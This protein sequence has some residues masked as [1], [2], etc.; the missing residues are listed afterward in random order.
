MWRIHFTAEDVARTRLAD[1]PRPLV[2]LNAAVRMLQGATRNVRLGSWRR[3]TLSRLP[4][5]TRMLFDLIPLQEWGLDLLTPAAA[6]SPE[7][8]L[9]QVRTSSRRRL[10]RELS[11]L[12]EQREHRRRLPR[13]AERMETEPRFFQHV[14]DLLGHLHTVALAPHWPRLVSLAL[15]DRGIRTRQFLDG[16]M[17]SLMSG[18]IPLRARWEP[19]TLEI[20]KPGGV[21]VDIHLG[22]RGLL[23]IPSLFATDFPIIDPDARPQPWITYPVHHDHPVDLL[24]PPAPPGA[25]S[26]LSTL[27]GRTRAAVLYAIGE[28]PASTT[29]EL[30]AHLGI[31][32]ASASEH[33]TT[34]RTAGLIST[35]RHR[36]SA[37][38]TL[39]VTGMDLLNTPAAGLTRRGT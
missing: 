18:L 26:P 9:E 4:R 34:L 27:L 3:D 24:I 19:A 28:H 7:E 32:P 30:A 25:L 29:G 16:G 2:E 11:A 36:T 12:A 6:G 14:V 37:I 17:D 15:V 22:G 31:A 1:G 8:L 35:A 5:Q 21:D 13:W 38:H 20:S 10:R 23:L 33:A 39:T